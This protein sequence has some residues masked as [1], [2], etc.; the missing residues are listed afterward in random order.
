MTSKYDPMKVLKKTKARV[1]HECHCCGAPISKGNVYYCEHVADRF[2]H[3]LH[4]RKFCDTC[5][6]E[7]GDALLQTR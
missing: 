7:R 4:A 2:L 1:S 6:A 3:I 5:F